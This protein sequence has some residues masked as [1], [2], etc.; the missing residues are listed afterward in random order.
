MIEYVYKSEIRSI[1]I[2]PIKAQHINMQKKLTME[3]CRI[4][5]RFGFVYGI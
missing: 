2:Y 4:N 3:D 5:S 1:Y